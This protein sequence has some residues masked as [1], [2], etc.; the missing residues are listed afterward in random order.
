MIFS[1]LNPFIAPSVVQTTCLLLN[2]RNVYDSFP[3]ISVTGLEC[4]CRA[5][6]SF[7]YLDWSTMKHWKWGKKSGLVLFC[8]VFFAGKRTCKTEGRRVKTLEAGRWNRCI[9]EEGCAW[10]GEGELW[11][12]ILEGNVIGKKCLTGKN[13]ATSPLQQGRSW[14]SLQLIST[15]WAKKM[16]RGTWME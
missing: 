5:M 4:A 3:D 11:L 12:S 1:M 15:D 8:F 13:G 16:G 14:R 6:Q 9:Q 7:F 10:L 2:R